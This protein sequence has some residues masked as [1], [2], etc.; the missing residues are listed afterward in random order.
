MEWYR[1]V[2]FIAAVPMPEETAEELG[3]TVNGMWAGPPGRQDRTVAQA[4]A[5][6]QRVLFSVPLIALVPSVYQTAETRHLL[7][8]VCRDINGG[9]AVVPWYYWE[10][11][12]VYAMCIYSPV[13]R[14]Y[15]FDRCREGIDRQM[16]VVNLDEI[17]TNIGLLSREAGA[18]GFC[19][20]CLDRFRGHLQEKY[21]D[22]AS[23]VPKQDAVVL[24]KYDEALRRLLRDD[25]NLYKRYRRFHER[26]AFRI[27]VHFIG[28]LR[29][30]AS[31]VN[32]EFAVTANLAYLGNE[33]ITRGDLWG[34][35][36][37]QHIDF[38][39]M[40][41]IY[42]T[43]PGGPHL[44]LPRGKF[45]A[46]YRLGSAFSSHAPTWICPSIMVPRQLAGQ[47][48]TQY[49]LLMFLEAYA[50]GGRWGYY[51]WPG[52]DE[53]TRLEATV[54]PQLK[55]YISFIAK[56]RRY[57]EQVESMNELA[58][59]YLDNS[60]SRKPE[61]HYKYLALAQAMAEAGYQF[62][63]LYEGSNEHNLTAID[64]QRLE[65]YRALLIP[66]AENLGNREAEA[67]TSYARRSDRKV[68]AYSEVPID[69]RKAQRQG[70]T[71][72]FDFWNNYN[73]A[74]RQ[75]ICAPLAS[76]RAARLRT[77]DPL[78][79]VIRYVK[80]DEQ[81]LHLL[82]YRYDA[83]AD[84]VVPSR[85]LRICVPW[86]PGSEPACTLLSLA[87]EDRLECAFENE[88]LVLEIPQ[89]DL[90]G[91]VILSR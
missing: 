14:R 12:P 68:V 88:D 77:S 59:L 20:Y 15:L 87:G 81:V 23:S 56:H 57:Y 66:E 44:L 65:S 89:F 52:V 6:G 1:Q 26:E 54:P 91:L 43:E 76:Y 71:V 2:Q 16:D 79:N 37:G 61:A 17:N 29:D 80:G 8:E 31:S 4:H 47:A 5:R 86:Q 35:R 83:I 10:S 63:V 67:L 64:P 25:G 41:N 69:L 62:D 34:P 60:I 19:H 28:E 70:E 46:W 82:N 53:Q 73:D 72:L 85:Q 51:W 49:Y 40:E 13:F 58:I 55:E 32:P 33:V 48:R 9:Q 3:T 84:R 24:G 21:A 27:A 11:A 38:V 36:W 74:D 50:N 90:H 39:M 18:P 7:G 42:Q 22:P 78:V 30:Y 45:T 75:R